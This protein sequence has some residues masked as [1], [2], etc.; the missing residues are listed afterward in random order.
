MFDRPATFAIVIL[1]S[2]LVTVANRVVHRRYGVIDPRVRYCKWSGGSS[3]SKSGSG[4]V[5]T[6][7]GGTLYYLTKRPVEHWDP[8][9]VYLGRDLADATRAHGGQQA[10]A[11]PGHRHR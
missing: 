6:T 8:Q 5:N 1:T 4:S 7:K 10:G 9:R 11:G 2:F 3:P